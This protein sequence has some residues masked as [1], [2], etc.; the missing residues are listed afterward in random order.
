VLQGAQGLQGIQGFTGA[1]GTKVYKVCRRSRT[2]WNSR[3]YW[4]AGNIWPNQCARRSRASGRYWIGK[5]QSAR[6][7]Q[8]ELKAQQV[9]KAHRGFKVAKVQLDFKV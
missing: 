8:Q 6:R 3:L 4:I 7:E 5:A 2:N 1:Q 9:H